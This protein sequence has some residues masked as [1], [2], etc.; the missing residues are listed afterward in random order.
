M[1][2]G[3]IE[4]SWTKSQKRKRI[5]QL[6]VSQFSFK[7]Q[8]DQF[9]RPMVLHGHIRN[10]QPACVRALFL[11]QALRV[12]DLCLWTVVGPVLLLREG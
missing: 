3:A 12:E 4:Y 2:S 5:P 6:Q 10:F 1:H 9:R 8:R 11:S 7:A